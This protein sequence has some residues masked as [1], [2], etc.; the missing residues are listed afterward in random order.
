MTITLFSPRLQAAAVRSK[1][2]ILAKNLPAN[3][4]EEEIRTMFERFGHLGRVVLPPSGITAIVEF[5]EP[6]EARS[7]FRGLAYTKVCCDN[8]TSNLK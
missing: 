1:T 6:T 7:A 4:S 3:T 5:L 2:V 8:E